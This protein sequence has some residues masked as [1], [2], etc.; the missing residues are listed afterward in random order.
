MCEHLLS[1]SDASGRYALPEFTV[2]CAVSKQ[3]LLRDEVELSAVSNHPVGKWLL[4]TSEQSGM[5]A[6][7]EH[8]DRCEFT[9]AEILKSEVAISEGSGKRYRAISR[10]DLFIRKIWARSE[11]VTCFITGNLL[12]ATEAKPVLNW[13][14]CVPRDS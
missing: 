6:E 11:F 13:S 5:R 14:R 2:I 8:F 12:M 9:H 4:K 1:Q 10:S 3:R 7:P